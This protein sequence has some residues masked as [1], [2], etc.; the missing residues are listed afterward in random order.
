LATVAEKSTTARSP[1]SRAPGRFAAWRERETW[2]AYLFLFPWIFGFLTLTL[3]PMI[4]SAYLS[5]T[6]YGVQQIAG[7]EPTE[8]VGA[9]HYRE[10]LHDDKIRLALKNTFVFTAMMV[11]AT[12]IVALALALI[13]VRIGRAAGFFRTVFYVPQ[14]TPPV[15]V[16]VLLLVLF[17]GQVGLIN[18]FLGFFGI[19]GPF[20]TTDPAWIKPSLVITSV[21]SVGG[22]MVIYLAALHGVPKQLYEAAAIDG[23]S[24]WRQFRNITLPMISPSLFFTFIIL[25]IAGLNSFTEAYTAYFGAGSSG[26][27]SPDAALF[28]AIYLFRQAFEF[29]NLGF[30]SAMAWLLFAITM[31]ITLVQVLVSRRFVFY[32]G[33]R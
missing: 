6:N 26:A 1:Q 11:P 3:G 23:A 28:Y 17:N 5:F 33:E 24:P 2:T 8:R 30:A 14:I 29:F 31:V 15:A 21:W 12:M 19:E 22:T 25:T 27:E 16:A 18:Q 13:L 4:A 7:F 10:L 9:E 20:W 32:Q